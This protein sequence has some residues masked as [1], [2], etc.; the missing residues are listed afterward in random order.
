MGGVWRGEEGGNYV[1]I[2]LTYKVLKNILIEKEV[3][4]RAKGSAVSLST[5]RPAVGLCKSSTSRSFSDE[6]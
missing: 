1:N 4:R 2:L 5:P 3:P 6:G